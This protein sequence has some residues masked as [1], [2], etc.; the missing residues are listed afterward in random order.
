MTIADQTEF[1]AV[2]RF[3]IDVPITHYE[4]QSDE[5]L[6]RKAQACRDTG[7]IVERFVRER[8]VPHSKE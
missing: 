3:T 4:T 1:S 8:D 6:I 5:S 7:T 2:V